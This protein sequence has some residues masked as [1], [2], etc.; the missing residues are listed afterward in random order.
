MG[1]ETD[2]PDDTMG[3][4]TSG[5]R[6]RL[7]LLLEADRW[8]VASL[9][10]AVVFGSLVVLGTL[11]PVPLG[12]AI[13]ASDPVETLFQALVAAI[14]TGVTLVVTITQLVLSQELGAVGDQRER[15]DGAMAFRKHVEGLLESSISPP[16]PSAFL[17]AIVLL[18]RDRAEALDNAVAASPDG[19]LRQRTR[20]YVENLSSHAKQVSDRIENTQFG[21]FELLSAALD[22]NYSWKLYAARRLRNEH[23]T[24]LTEAADTAFDEVI[25]ALEAF[26]TAREHIKTLYFQWAL[27]DLS[28]SI[29]YASI[30]ALVVAIGAIL[31]LDDPGTVTGATAGVDNVLWVVSAATTVALVPFMILLAYVLRIVTVAQRTLAIGPF[32]LRETDRTRDIEREG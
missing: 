5:S 11:D 27:I 3:G 28:R 7:W 1:A 26:G 13:E 18:T 14:I 2:Q 24:D 10:L 17:R 4:R 12:Q 22:F 30:P 9:P 29:L 32:I 19:A 8:I 23:A 16:E 31:F 6:L 15:M 21:T 25:E 20:D